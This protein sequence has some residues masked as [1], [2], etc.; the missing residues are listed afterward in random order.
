MK[1]HE[2]PYGC[3]FANC[4]KLFGSKND[5]ERHENSQHFHWDCWRC[6]EEK[7][8]GGVC[9][10]VCHCRQPYEDHLRKEHAISDTE[11]L[12][13][14]INSALID[15]NLEFRFWCGFCVEVVELRRKSVET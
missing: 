4:N 13:E 7:K 11:V 2:R 1:R 3:T 10:K 8:G 12:T 5:W 6:G 15:Q 14:K 9:A